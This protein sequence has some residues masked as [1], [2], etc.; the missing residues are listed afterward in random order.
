MWDQHAI[1]NELGIADPNDCSCKQE[2]MLV[3]F[4]RVRERKLLARFW[5]ETSKRHQAL[6]RDA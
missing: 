2:V 1:A 3:W 6:N 5:E 4:R